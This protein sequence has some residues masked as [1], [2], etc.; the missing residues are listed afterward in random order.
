LNQNFPNPFNPT[1][2][3]EYWL[4]SKEFVTVSVFDILGRKCTELAE[5]FQD[6]G[7]HSILFD[8]SHFT[9]GVYFCRLITTKGEAATK[10]MI[11][12]H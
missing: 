5:G 12:L 8:G 3:I 11:L 2:T 1:T 6:A 7:F 4:S 9:S 10:S